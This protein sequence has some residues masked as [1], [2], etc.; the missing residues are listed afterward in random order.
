LR[1]SRSVLLCSGIIPELGIPDPLVPSD[2]DYSGVEPKLATLLKWL[3]KSRSVLLCSGIIP[4]LGIPDPLGRINMENFNEDIQ[5]QELKIESILFNNDLNKKYWKYHDYVYSKIINTESHPLHKFASLIESRNLL[6]LASQNVDNLFEKIDIPQQKII[7][8]NGKEFNSFCFQCS[9]PS[10]RNKIYTENQGRYENNE[11]L[12]V[13]CEQCGGP[14]I[15]ES[16]DASL[17]DSIG[18]LRGAAEQCDL[19]IL[20]GDSLLVPPIT[21]II[22]IVLSMGTKI[23]MITEN[24]DVEETAFDLVIHGPINILLSSMIEHLDRKRRFKR[25]SISVHSG[26]R[27]RGMGPVLGSTRI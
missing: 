4:E 9:T 10:D 7:Y 23:A 15:V 26:D 5:I 21:E 25:A 3:R 19:L 14:I 2:D 1:K 18:N 8:I 22:P 20:I 17:S 6:N 16:I 24:Y 27:Y 12:N 11:S 13:K